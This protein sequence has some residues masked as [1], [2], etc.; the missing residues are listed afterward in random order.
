MGSYMATFWS[1]FLM[2][3]VFLE[4]LDLAL[5]TIGGM[6]LNFKS[7]RIQHAYQVGVMATLLAMRHGALPPVLTA[8]W[9]ASLLA[10]TPLAGLVAELPITLL[11]I[12][13]SIVA[14]FYAVDE[15][16]GAPRAAKEP[17]STIAGAEAEAAAATA[18]KKQL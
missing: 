2:R 3:A 15:F 6:V 17:A 10:S 5:I 4:S 11:L 12:I 9:A 1:I 14:A 18:G 13:M 16:L 8:R 7:V